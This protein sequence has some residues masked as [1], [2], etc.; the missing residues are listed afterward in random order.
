[1]A[2]GVVEGV[3]QRGRAHV[4]EGLHA[5]PAPAHLLLLVHALDHELVDRAFHERGRDRLATPFAGNVVHQ[6]ALFAIEVAEQLSDVL[7]E[8]LDPGDLAHMLAPSPST[9]AGVSALTLAIASSCR[10]ASDAAP[11]P[12][13][14]KA[15][16]GW[17]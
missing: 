13:R 10:N 11:W 5:R 14:T 6:R 4:V 8:A 12:L 15:K 9:A 17:T 1:M 2:E 3:V 7:L 16:R